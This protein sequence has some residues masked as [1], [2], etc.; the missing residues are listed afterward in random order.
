[1]V[2][3][4]LYLTYAWKGRNY[5]YC[6]INMTIKTCFPIGNFANSYKSTVAYFFFY[7]TYFW[8]PCYFY[9]SN[10]F[11]TCLCYYQNRYIVAANVSAIYKNLWKWQENF[12][13]WFMY[14]SASIFCKCDL[15]IRPCRPVR[16]YNLPPP[17]PTGENPVTSSSIN[18]RLFQMQ[19]FSTTKYYCVVM[20]NGKCWN[21]ICFW[22]GLCR[23]T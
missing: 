7:D 15:V 8:I 13:W 23:R 2:Q 3:V 5:P 16:K 18:Y 4:K 14:R 22:M 12:C 21:A 11:T 19:L 6:R 17:S 10:L 1:M 9:L 20:H